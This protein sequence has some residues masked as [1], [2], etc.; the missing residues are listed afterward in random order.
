MGL[1]AL[2]HHLH[3]LPVHI[4]P[5]PV[6]PWLQVQV[7]LPGVLVQAALVWQLTVSS[8]HSS[9]SEEY[10]GINIYYCTTGRAIQGNIQFKGGSIGPTAYSTVCPTQKE[11]NNRFIGERSE[12]SN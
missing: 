2:F 6:Y 4:T 8:L 1:I 11:C 10:M 3:Y 9:I 12:P 7:K 5:F